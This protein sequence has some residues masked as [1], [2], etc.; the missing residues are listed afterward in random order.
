[1][2][3]RGKKKIEL[4]SRG[5]R[6]G[7]PS[8]A[9]GLKRGPPCPR[10]HGIDRSS[11]HDHHFRADQEILLPLER[12]DPSPPVFAPLPDSIQLHLS[13]SKLLFSRRLL[14][15]LKSDTRCTSR[16]TASLKSRAIYSHV[17]ATNAIKAPATAKF[18]THRQR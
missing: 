6:C 1:M 8:S 5:G 13:L 14:I 17:P 2:S 7:I 15:P 12:R 3:V 4:T 9:T 18:L 11:L 16:P 10:E